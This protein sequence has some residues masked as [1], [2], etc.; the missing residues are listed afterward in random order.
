MRATFMNKLVFPEAEDH[1]TIKYVHHFRVDVDVLI[2]HERR[3]GRDW[4]LYFMAG[5]NTNI[6]DEVRSG[7]I[8]E[9]MYYVRRRVKKGIHMLSF[10]DFVDMTEAVNIA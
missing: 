10:D 2:K 3:H 8:K 4:E 7:L 6:P 5:K 9:F 1:T